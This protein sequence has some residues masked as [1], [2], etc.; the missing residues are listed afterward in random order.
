[1]A[2]EPRGPLARYAYG[3][4]DEKPGWSYWLIVAFLVVGS[5]ALATSVE[6]VDP[7]PNS[8]SSH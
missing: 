5:I 7:E 8:T 6:I 3:Y 2:K 1:M 4:S